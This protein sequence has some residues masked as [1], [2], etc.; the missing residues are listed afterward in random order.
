MNPEQVKRLQLLC[1][2]REH[3]SANL[4]DDEINEYEHLVRIYFELMRNV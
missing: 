1:D 2:K 4:T 3:Y